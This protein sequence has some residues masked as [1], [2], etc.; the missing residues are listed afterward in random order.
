MRLPR[1]YQCVSWVLLLGCVL[2][3]RPAA[4]SGANVDLLTLGNE[5]RGVYGM[6]IDS[7]D[8]LWVTSF[9][10]RDILRLD[11]RTGKILQR[12]TS[13]DGIE[14]PDDVDFSG[15]G[16]MYWVTI[17][18]GSIGRRTPGGAVSYQFVAPGLNAMAFSADGRL[19]ASECHGGTGGIYEVDP[20][21]LAP[22]RL[23]T[24]APADAYCGLTVGPDGFIY[25]PRWFSGDVVRIDPQ[26]GAFTIVAGGLGVPV[27]TEFDR[28]GR[29]YVCDKQLGEVFRINVHTGSKTV[30]ARLPP[31]I[32]DIG[33][34]SH[35]TSFVS[36]NNNGALYKITTRGDVSLVRPPGLA[37]PGGVAVVPRGRGAD[38]VVVAD[39]TSL[40]E[41]NAR[42]GSLL[43]FELSNFTTSQPGAGIARPTN[44]SWDG[45]NLILVSWPENAVQV[46]NRATGQ[47]VL[48]A[49]DFALPL[50]AIR[51]Q[52]D[53]IVAELATG[54]VVRSSA[55]GTVRSTLMGGLSIPAGLAA[56]DDDLWVGDAA[57]GVIWQVV[58]DGVVLSTPQQVAG[59]LAEPEGLAV[60]GNGNLLVV[61]AAA[62]RLRRIDLGTGVVTTI[63]SNLSLG[64]PFVPDISVPTLW[65]N[66]VTVAESGTIYVTGDIGRVVY[67]ITEPGP[68]CV[69]ARGTACLLDGRYQAT[70]R[71][72]DQGDNGGA[73]AHAERI[74]RVGFFKFRNDGI[75]QL[76]VKLT[77]AC[78]AGG[79]RIDRA[80]LTSAEY[81]LTVT[82]TK[83]GTIRE[84]HQTL[85]G[86]PGVASDP[87]A[88]PCD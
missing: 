16:S 15:D 61:E 86:G 24:E 36:L 64:M 10:G 52:G 46:R 7:H 33:V 17:V 30:I 76:A 47:F 11:K 41:F 80:W 42:N 74:G 43:R 22:P 69:E 67:R 4:A 58:A 31:G 70:V 73:A 44:V 82:D 55:D 88:F 68:H 18:T 45:E 34:D 66:G 38:G 54:Q 9:L 26:T 85:A 3:P 77:K 65:F 5:I 53:L 28:Q 39:T 48:D 2:A 84:Y 83:T 63:A 75:P 27:S 6:T 72:R 32:D 35:G 13:D 57:T 1:G 29:L 87:A 71:W 50:N 37:V 12:F 60:D 79:I 20:H 14:T 62:G 56:T 51:F 8:E 59:G 19:F 21:L 78:S 23:I 40:S 81:Q 49:R 25:A